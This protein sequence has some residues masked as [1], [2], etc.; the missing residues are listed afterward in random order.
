MTSVQRPFYS[1]NSNLKVN[2]EILI[3]KIVLEHDTRT[4][5]I[6]KNLPKK[7]QFK[8]LE[9]S[10]NLKFEKSYDLLKMPV[11]DRNN[12]GFAFINFKFF[13]SIIDFC[14]EFHK[15]STLHEIFNSKD[16]TYLEFYHI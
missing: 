3:N 13:R 12:L 16:H 8:D 1:K 9:N 5:L 14:K 2:P 4:T 6:I 7:C 15:K 11:D 10:I